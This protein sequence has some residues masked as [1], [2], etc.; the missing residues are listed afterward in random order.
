MAV[1]SQQT[2]LEVK[3]AR[4]E[5]SQKLAAKSQKPKMTKRKK[6]YKKKK[7]QVTKKQAPKSSL[8]NYFGIA[9]F[10]GV[11]FLAFLF[12]E[13]IRFSYLKM[14]SIYMVYKEK[15]T[16]K[17]EQTKIQKILKLHEKHIFGLD[18]SHYQGI[19]N[20]DKVGFLEDSIPVSFVILRATAGNNKSDN[21]FTYNWRESKKN[22]FTRGAYH[23]YRPDENSTEQ[24][25]KFI[26][27]VTLEKGDLPP[28][29]DIE[30]VSDIQTVASLR[31][32]IS[33]W[34]EIVEK[35]YGIKPI[36][37]TGDSFYKDYLK[38]KGY[39][40]Y[41]IWI[42]NYNKHIKQPKVKD[43][44]IWQF[45]DQGTA[46]GINEFVDLNV[47]D[48]NEKMLGLLLIK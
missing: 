11:I 18:I 6:T 15:Y 20:W 12:Q 16:T 33:N 28:I 40:D 25:E 39:N 44:I 38:G 14:R 7:K 9:L 34:L 10:I 41:P 4:D 27:K 2:I 21:Y 13:E 8:K 22:N 29:L 23:Y 17:V 36:I 30:D 24:A 35:H 32:G 43:W 47:F 42:A 26:S 19:I 3:T 31:K 5:Q 1:D 37:Y 45:S 48:G 46:T